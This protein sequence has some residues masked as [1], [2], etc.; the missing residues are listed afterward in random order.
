MRKYQIK[1]CLIFLTA[2]SVQGFSQQ[3]P[4]DDHPQSYLSGQ[5]ARAGQLVHQQYYTQA[6]IALDSALTSSEHSS[7]IARGLSLR[8]TCEQGVGDNIGADNDYAA[9]IKFF[10]DEF[11]AVNALRNRGMLAYDQ[12]QYQESRAYMQQC[13]TR[14]KQ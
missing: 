8:A 9:I 10:P 4:S 11:V 2:L 12:K 3:F 7:L 13:I 6:R 1:L 14:G 5:I